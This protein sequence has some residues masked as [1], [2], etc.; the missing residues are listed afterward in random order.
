MKKLIICFL[1]FVLITPSLSADLAK[2]ID[3]K[4]KAIVEIQSPIERLKKIRLSLKEFKNPMDRIKFMRAYFRHK[5][6]KDEESNLDKVLILS[7]YDGDTY[8]INYKGEQ[9]KI[10]L[11]GVD[12]PEVKNGK[13]LSCLG[14][15]VKE[16][17][18]NRITNKNVLMSRDDK[19]HRDGFGRLLRYVRIGTQDLG[20]DLLLRGYAQVYDKGTFS[21]KREYIE[22]ED[23][24]REKKLGIWGDQCAVNEEAD[25]QKNTENEPVD[26]LNASCQL[27]PYCT[28]LNS[29]EEAK[30]YLNTC[31]LLRLDQD[32][33]GIPCE[34]L[35]GN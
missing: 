24:A 14:E 15:E 1:A 23:T 33:D 28:Q 35:C 2:D 4:S 10:R 17:V 9:E 8:T 16:Y 31:G 13:K 22:Y 12:T 19:L 5:K 6:T 27:K 26:N 32:K 3:T 29:C 20:K 11:L 34:S 30:Y 21:K 7:V 18:E 25:T